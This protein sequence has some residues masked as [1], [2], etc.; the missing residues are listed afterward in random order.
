MSRL[1]QARGLKQHDGAGS[2]CP[3]RVAPHAGA[4]IETPEMARPV[5]DEF[6][7]PHAGAWIETSFRSLGWSLS[8]ILCVRAYH[9]V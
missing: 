3:H 4:W 8:G 9:D 1:T 6:V 7:A 5:L 2:G